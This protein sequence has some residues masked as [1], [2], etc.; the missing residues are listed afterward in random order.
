[1]VKLEDKRIYV[2]VAGTVQPSRGNVVQPIGR[3]AA[4][5]CHVVS[6]LRLVNTGLMFPEVRNFE[7]FTTIILQARDSA[8][9]LHVRDLLVK[10][11]LHPALFWDTNQEAYGPGEIVTAVAVFASK[12]Q[13]EGILDYLP[14]WGAK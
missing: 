7:A 3:Q 14:L 13:V 11:K 8:E 5:A 1:M 2:A 10:R 12:K 9:L 4:Q 6:K